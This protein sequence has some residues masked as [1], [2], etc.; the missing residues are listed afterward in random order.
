MR[1][2]TLMNSLELAKLGGDDIDITAAGVCVCVCVCVCVSVSVCVSVGGGCVC[3]EMY[4]KKCVHA[5]V[6]T[7]A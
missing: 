5:S 4:A 1:C 7:Y 3:V 6:S 2:R